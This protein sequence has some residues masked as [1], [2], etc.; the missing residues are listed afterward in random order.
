MCLESGSNP[1]PI[2]PECPSI[3]QGERVDCFPDAGASQVNSK[4][5]VDSQCKEACFSHT[6]C[7]STAKMFGKRM[8]LESPGRG[9]HPLVF[10]LQK[11]RL[12]CGQRAQ[13]G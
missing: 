2:V 5:T 11:P 12:R 1:D 6:S 7:E 9:Q 13:A 3:P 10:L 4:A 8:L